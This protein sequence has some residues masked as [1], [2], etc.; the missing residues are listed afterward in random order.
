MT[1]I[2][3]SHPWGLAGLA[4]IGA[5]VVLYLF[6][7][8]HR[9]R[10]VTGLFL[11]DTGRAPAEKGRKPGR[12]AVGRSLLLDLLAAVL[13]S[14]ALAGATCSGTNLGGLVVVLD[15]SLS[16]RAFDNHHRSLRSVQDLLSEA[17]PDTPVLVF[18]AGARP[19]LR[20]RGQAGGSQARR[21]FEKIAF[22]A[23][24]D[25]VLEAVTLARELA[26]GR[27]EFHVFTDHDL[28]LPN[29][30]GADVIRHVWQGRGPNVALTEVHRGRPGLATQERVTV[31][32][33]NFSEFSQAVRLHLVAEPPGG[34]LEGQ[35][36]ESIRSDGPEPDGSAHEQATHW[37]FFSE[38]VELGPG[39]R[40]LF[41][42]DLPHSVGPVRVRVEAREDRL[43]DD[44]TARLLPAPNGPVT[45]QLLVATPAV[46]RTL[47]RALRAA[48]AELVS[49]PADL[50]VL[51]RSSAFDGG[52]S[53]RS[54]LTGEKKRASTEGKEPCSKPA[55]RGKVY[56]L[57]LCTPRNDVITMV[58]PFML[59]TFDPLV[60]NVDLAGVYWTAD[61]ESRS[62]E[63][64]ALISAGSIALYAR[65]PDGL[66]EL[67]LDLVQSNLP[68]HPAWPTLVSNL[69]QVVEADRPGLG[70]VN[71]QP[72]DLLQFRMPR[73]HASGSLQLL[74]N[75]REATGGSIRP[76]N[77]VPVRL[78]EQ[79]GEYQVMLDG[80]PVGA[81]VVNAVAPR[82]SDLRPLA[83]TAS[84]SRKNALDP[85]PS[86]QGHLSLVR[87]LVLAGIAV[88]GLN[89]WLEHRQEKVHEV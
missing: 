28:P 21:I 57:V 23:Q 87:W 8:Q 67:N 83:N 74:H 3:F 80:R 50:A 42:V 52:N 13:F 33:R 4:A 37:S 51:E 1:G 22:S 19:V 78:P 40:R 44:S 49:G 5:I 32:V 16:M 69:V 53:H 54:H 24:K 61:R 73:D 26:H 43:R 31:V 34:N 10:R 56:T 25:S 46:S 64:P 82:E 81:V 72:G 30:P 63:R 59:H 39:G 2:A 76:G 45:A 86:R 7:E 12:L 14:L 77:R 60:R 11:W 38:P 71:Y 75:G 55:V 35:T 70:R 27:L 47:A 9:H 18:E 15:T 65:R 29:V 41:Q 58:G 6:V 85:E 89:W 36:G 62:H 79:A 68:R 84:M 17:D 88:L 66:L 20:Y 48:G